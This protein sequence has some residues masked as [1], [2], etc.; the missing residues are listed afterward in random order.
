MR[1]QGKSQGLGADIENSNF[2]LLS[3]GRSSKYGGRD[4]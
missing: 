3:R 4:H 1:L 2:F